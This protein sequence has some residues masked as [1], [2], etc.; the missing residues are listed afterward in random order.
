[1]K[2]RRLF[3]A[4]AGH[5]ITVFIENKPGTLAAVIDKLRDGNVNMLALSLNEGL[6]IGYL[7]IAVDKL[8]AAK[9]ILDEAGQLVIDHTVVLLEVAN[10]PGGL[11]AASDRWAK[12]GIN[13]EYAYSATSPSP[14]R[15]VIVVRVNDPK[16]AIAVLR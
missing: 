1:M 6:D 14:D 16:R 15:S 7:R 4:R 11:A 10:E 13:I 3:S 12:A 8:A 5:Q 2:D 9:K